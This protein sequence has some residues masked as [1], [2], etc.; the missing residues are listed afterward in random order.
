MIHRNTLEFL[1]DMKLNNSKE[2]I[3][4]NKERYVFA[5]NDVLTFTEEL[6]IEVSEFDVN[7]S[8]ANLSASRCIQDST[9]I[10]DFQRIKRLTRRITISS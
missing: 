9:E 8:N 1:R 2:W 6:I 10:C 3:E 7:I 4:E 5:K